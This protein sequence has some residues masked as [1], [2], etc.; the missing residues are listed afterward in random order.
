MLLFIMKET[1]T[2]RTFK[3]V[4]TKKE[5]EQEEENVDPAIAKSR[6]LQWPKSHCGYVYMDKYMDCIQLCFY[7]E[8][9]W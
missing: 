9:V 4:S 3:E 8:I 2:S 5:E 7:P 6:K 1:F